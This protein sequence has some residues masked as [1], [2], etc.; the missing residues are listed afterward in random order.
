MSMFAYGAIHA[1]VTW[2][3]SDD[4]TLTIYGT[5]M[6]NYEYNESPWHFHLDKIKKVVLE[7]GITNIGVYAFSDCRNLTSVSIP[8][9]VVN[10]GNAAFIG[11]ESLSSITIPNSVT[12]IGESVFSYCTSLTSITIPKSVSYID[13]GIAS[14]CPN[15]I[16][17]TV[18]E[19]NKN[20]DSRDN[21][22]AIIDKKY[23]GL[24]QGCQNTI[25][26]NS[27]T[28]IWDWA[29]DECSSLTSITIPNSV[30][31]IGL[32]AFCGCSS[33]ASITIPK[34][35]RII[36]NGAFQG[37][38]GL[39]SIIVEE[40]NAKY[41]SRNDC[42]AIVETRTNNLVYGCKNTVIPNSINRIEESAF[43]GCEELTSIVIPNS[44]TS[45]GIWAFAWCKA[46][47][48]V[49]I[50]SSIASLDNSVFKGCVSLSKVN[51]YAATPPAI[52]DEVFVGVPFDSSIL[53]V[54]A[55]SV[56]A[57]QNANGWNEWENILPI[58]EKESTSI[59]DIVKGQSWDE[60]TY[61]LN[62]LRIDGYDTHKGIYIKNGKKFVR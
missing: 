18:E 14:H 61:N 19:G 59:G 38:S 20:Y 40:G 29:F 5:K 17:I 55:S 37:C 11:C 47:S 46:L 57:Y 53:N 7:E 22:N 52:G 31:I 23:N 56:S 3:I 35:V 60:K 16:S 2:K 36:G 27:V 42:N 9:T 44:V 43:W 50:P 13:F 49:T 10:I 26:P 33:L 4:G 1:D 25:I 28:R 8:N 15:L 34:S 54:P 51:C 24:L 21:C 62:G 6:D 48:S 30:S 32:A 39:S 45:I 41:D 58:E 12:S